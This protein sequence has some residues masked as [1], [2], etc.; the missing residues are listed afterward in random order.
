MSDEK[1]AST[2]N[3][4]GTDLRERPSLRS[5]VMRRVTQ[6]ALIGRPHPDRRIW[7]LATA[8]AACAVFAFVVLQ[9]RTGDA[10]KAYA[11][12]IEK[13]AKAH[14]FSC[15]E[16][17]S[18][19]PD[20]KNQIREI[21]TY[22]KEPDRERVEIHGIHDD[23][24]VDIM[25][26]AT[27]RRLSLYPKSKTAQ[28]YEGPFYSVDSKTGQIEPAKLDTSVRDQ[29]MSLT[30][31]A[32]KDLGT[33]KVEGKTVRVL[34]SKGKDNTRT[35]YADPKTHQPVQIVIEYPNGGKWT[36]SDIR[37]DQGLDDKLFSLEVPADYHTM[38]VQ[39]PQPQQ[40]H[41]IRNLMRIRELANACIIYANDHDGKFP[42]QLANL[43]GSALNEVA[44]KNLSE[45]ILYRSPP[46]KVK[47]PTAQIIL[48][49]A[50][51]QREPGKIA[52]G[53][54]DGHG[55]V[56]TQENFDKAMK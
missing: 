48:Y 10:S 25:H 46:L 14:T 19:P 34:Q 40:D 16:I 56:M 47:D 45:G 44:L 27:H 5:E 53:M 15:R 52:V 4:I 30:A 6:T 32:V 55:E 9:F 38:E 39:K 26:Y 37:I 50:A 21:D 3:D 13:V 35:V 12:A 20:D 2:L 54:M 42:N 7:G 33:A 24:D 41:A 31:E 17:W 51:D 11:D 8:L 49:E 43:T 36:Y 23:G 29:V 1:T 28:P 22:F 18:G